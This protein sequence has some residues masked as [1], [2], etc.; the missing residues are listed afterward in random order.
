M[1]NQAQLAPAWKQEVNQRI[2]AHKN[3]KLAP[4]ETIKS[5]AQTNQSASQRAASAAARVAARFAK[6]PS[7]SEQLAGEARAAVRAA[8]AVSR[9]ALEAQAAAE[10]MLAELEAAQQ[11]EAG[12]GLHSGRQVEPGQQ[13]STELETPTAGSETENEVPDHESPWQPDAPLPQAESEASGTDAGF[14]ETAVSERQQNDRQQNGWPANEEAT[15]EL[16]TAA[17]EVVQPIHANLIEFPRE[18]VAPRKARPRRAEGP[19]AASF[20]SGAQLSIFEV[21][22]GAIS[23]DPAPAEPVSAA[24]APVWTGPEWSGMELEAQPQTEFLEEPAQAVAE[25]PSLEAAATPAAEQAPIDLRLMAALI[26]VSL[27]LAGFAFTAYAIL[28]HM[29][30]APALHTVELA[31]AAG[32]VLIAALYMGLF[33]ALGNVTPGMKYA[34]LSLCTMD[35]LNP[36]REQRLRRCVALLV[37]VLPVG[38]GVVWALFDEDRLCWHDRLS[39]TYLRRA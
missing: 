34:G 37:S 9:A 14:L 19:Y 36:K 25:E 23:T 33:H 12:W 29:R 39:G 10:S 31:G 2:A 13:E 6:A 22:P 17:V 24:S 8:E 16:T 32:F 27:I 11:A 38:L 28:S 7:Y 5:Q 35:G 4:V 21:D 3:R 26:D 20:E 1:A 30:T 18:I 15:G